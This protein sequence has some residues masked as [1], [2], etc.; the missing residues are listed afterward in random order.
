MWQATRAIADGVI[1][2]PDV[3]VTFAVLLFV[4]S[5]RQA[6]TR[7]G[8]HAVHNI[9]PLVRKSKQGKQL[10]E[11][12]AGNGAVLTPIKTVVH[13]GAEAV[14]KTYATLCEEVYA[15]CKKLPLC[16][17]GKKHIFRGDVDLIT[18]RP[19][20][21]HSEACS[22]VEFV[23]GKILSKDQ[24]GIYG[25]FYKKGR[26][27]KYSTFFPKNLDE[28]SICNLLEEA[29]HNPV[30]K[31]TSWIIGEAK[32]GMRIKIVFKKNTKGIVCVNAAYPLYEGIDD[33]QNLLA[34]LQRKSIHFK[35]LY[36]D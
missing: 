29:F 4:P 12:C 18:G 25:G 32:N 35:N 34:R 11:A 30:V 17:R 19:G 15:T 22:N 8:K 7:L 6:L 33:I 3:V 13:N 26:W 27:E 14:V 21:L 5:A 31:N 2:H 36:K 1:E 24:H 16:A 9:A 28:Q 23:V 10:A 20:G